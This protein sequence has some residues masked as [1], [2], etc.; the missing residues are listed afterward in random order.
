MGHALGCPQFLAT[1]SHLDDKRTCWRWPCDDTHRFDLQE[2]GI[3]KRWQLSSMSRRHTQSDSNGKGTHLDMTPTLSHDHSVCD[4][5]LQSESPALGPHSID[6]SDF[7]QM[8]TR[9][10]ASCERDQGHR[11]GRWRETRRV[12]K[13]IER[14]MEMCT[15]VHQGAKTHANVAKVLALSL[16]PSHVQEW[17]TQPTLTEAAIIVFALDVG[18]R[19]RIP[20][21]LPIATS[22]R[23]VV[24]L[25]HGRWG[26]HTERREQVRCG[27]S[28]TRLRE[29]R[30][31]IG[32]R[33]RELSRRWRVSSRPDGLRYTHLIHT[34]SERKKY[35]HNFSCLSQDPSLSH[36]DR[37]A[38]VNAVGV[39]KLLRG[40]QIAFVEGPA[41]I[42]YPKTILN[43]RMEPDEPRWEGVGVVY[44]HIPAGK[45]QENYN[46][47]EEEVRL[48]IL[49]TISFISNLS[50]DR[51]PLYIHCRFGKD[52]TGIIVALLLSLLGV[53]RELIILEYLMSTGHVKREYIE[54]VLSTFPADPEEAKKLFPHANFQNLA[55]LFRSE[56]DWL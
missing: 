1:S 41:S 35:I 8:R 33:E 42:G 7:G 22:C 9:P 54:K 21:P 48:W 27:V 55:F 25:T 19:V 44:A 20:A 43:I 40:G 23:G 51:L 45:A 29:G 11:G 34:N 15:W 2:F 50:S 49:Q 28:Q 52:R 6:S 14:E 17:A 46:I 16:H 5:T 53:P 32:E 30:D 36:N 39:G 24:I 47:E 38:A 26:H 13:E 12:E 4:T 3:N 31:H 10:C 37:R 18:L 56:N